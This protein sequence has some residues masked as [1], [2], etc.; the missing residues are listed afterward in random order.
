[1]PTYTAKMENTDGSVR[2]SGLLEFTS[3]TSVPLPS[4]SGAALVQAHAA[5]ADGTLAAGDC[6]LWFDQTN[7]AGKLMVK[8][9]TA[10]G[11]VATG[12]VALT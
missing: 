9:K 6:Y 7:G 1:M 3:A 8:A 11:T 2:L 4:L 10:D 5:P 12:S